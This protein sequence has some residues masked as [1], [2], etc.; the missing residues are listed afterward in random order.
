VGI[1]STSDD[2][3]IAKM[4]KE[5]Q[6][7]LLKF[8]NLKKND[9]NCPT[10]PYLLNPERIHLTSFEEQEHGKL[11]L[12]IRYKTSWSGYV[13]KSIRVRYDQIILGNILCEGVEDLKKVEYKKIGSIKLPL[14]S[15][16]K[17]VSLPFNGSY[18]IEFKC[19]ILKALDIDI[20]VEKE[21]K[22]I[23]DSDYKEMLSKE[24]EKN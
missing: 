8:Y 7:M 20:F 16:Y 19:K 5:E 9:P 24:L 23:L 17:I 13:T 14:L 18:S 4:E 15:K 6:D 1:F 21:G 2:K 22:L 12:K 3:F 11:H 10:L